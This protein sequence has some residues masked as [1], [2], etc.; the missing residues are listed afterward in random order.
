M[1]LGVS[2]EV[3]DSIC[4]TVDVE[5]AHPEVLADITRAFDERGLRATLFCT[6]PGITAGHHERALH[7]N[8][9]RSGDTMRRLAREHADFET[10][11]ESRVYDFVVRHTK[12]FCPEA[13]GVRA[14]SLLHD[15]ELTAVYRAHGLGYDS[16]VVLPFM[17]NITPVRGASSL[18][19]LPIYY[20][21]HMDISGAMTD[22][23]I[24]SLRLDRP[25]LKVFDFHPNIVFIN[26]RSND[27]YLASKECYH[28]PEK[29]AAMRR[30]G[31]GIRT[32]FFELIDYI[33]DR[34]IRSLS[35]GDVCDAIA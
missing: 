23:R 20:M 14:H 27:D 2:S 8:F 7:P 12:S 15:T 28:D 3:G 10:W 29:L 9:R 35:L 34:G 26:A 24:A 33:A 17:P 30:P 22:F 4:L 1:S 5:W 19:Q 25:G 18:L 13:L 21:D 11:S 6:H 32:M 16:S 31:R